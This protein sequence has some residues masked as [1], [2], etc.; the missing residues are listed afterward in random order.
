MNNFSTCLYE[1]CWILIINT[2]IN[3]F[4]DARWYPKQKIK[5]VVDKLNGVKPSKLTLLQIKDRYSDTEYFS[6]YIDVINGCDDG[7]QSSVRSMHKDDD[8]SV[9]EQVIFI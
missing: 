7:L 8:L 1:L 9:E 2:E 3:F 6:K 4:L 5:I